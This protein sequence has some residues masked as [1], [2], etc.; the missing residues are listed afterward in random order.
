MLERRSTSIAPVDR[1]RVSE[2][3]LAPAS[4]LFAL[5][6]LVVSA[7]VALYPAE[8]YLTLLEQASFDDPLTVHLAYDMLQQYPDSG[9]L[10]ATQIRAA[11]NHGHSMRAFDRSREWYARSHTARERTQAF[12]LGFEALR[13]ALHAGLAEDD[14]MPGVELR[15]WV[16]SGTAV[17][18]TPAERIEIAR[19][20]I[21]IGAMNESLVWLEDRLGE[22][23]GISRVAFE[24]D[25]ET[26]SISLSLAPSLAETRLHLLGEV[27]R[28]LGRPELI[29]SHWISRFRLAAS[30]DDARAAI[31]KLLDLYAAA[32]RGP[33]GLKI[34]ET[35]V[36][37]R[38]DVLQAR[39]LL[40]KLIRAALA[41]N[42]PDLA[43]L[44]A[45]ELAQRELI[46]R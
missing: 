24:A 2:P 5:A 19:T 40:A 18:L 29:A 13:Q 37:E 6:G 28:S 1:A 16:A 39:T 36:R 34:V 11:L 25:D 33:Q 38:P 7:L 10:Y 44:W 31:E 32:D 35:L 45:A 17:E 26:L 43:G 15:R 42:R 3:R 9:L 21:S 12:W 27:A 8:R 22:S 30:Q 14:R 4:S 20:L 46:R 23:Q 41:G